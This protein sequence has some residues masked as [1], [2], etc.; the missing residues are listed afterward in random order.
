MWKPPK[1]SDAQM[2]VARNA[3]RARHADDDNTSTHLLS[4]DPREVLAYLRRRGG[5]GLLDA[6]ITDALTIRLWL[7]WEG[8][9][10]EV[11]LLEQAEK[12]RLNRKKVG[13]VLGLTKGQSLVNRLDYKRDLIADDTADAAEPA[14]NR[15]Q[16]LAQHQDQLAA[17]AQTLVDYRDRLTEATAEELAGVRRD[18]RAGAWTHTSFTA[19]GWAVEEVAVDPLV[20]ELPAG[21]RLLLALAAWPELAAGY[22]PADPV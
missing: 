6:D 17:V 16:W 15:K 7:W 9:R 4:D 2:R 3:I 21:D 11:W 1:V 20:A 22:P 19:L 12:R 13:A 8:E 18:L 10:A 14:P 5:S